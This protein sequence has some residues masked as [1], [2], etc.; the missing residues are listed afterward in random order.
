LNLH[1]NTFEPTKQNRRFQKTYFGDNN[2]L[3]KTLRQGQTPKT[4]LIGCCDSRVDPAIIT[5]CD[6]GDLFVVRNVANLVA[7]YNPDKS[8]HGVSAALEFAVKG[9]KVQNI[10]IMGHTKCG[11]IEALMRGIC[12]SGETEFI[13]NWMRIAQRAK[14]KVLK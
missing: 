9:L 10:I 4:L 6:P 12:D 11:G 2:E 3:Y 14:E 7:P 13:G 1:L 8:Y 5:D